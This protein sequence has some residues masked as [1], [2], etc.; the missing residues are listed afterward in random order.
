MWAL[1]VAEVCE[2]DGS[3]RFDKCFMEI[4]LFCFRM[5]G[6]VEEKDREGRR[7]RDRWFIDIARRCVFRISTSYEA[8][9]VYNVIQRVNKNSI[10]AEILFINFRMK[11][12]NK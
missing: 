7:E 5:I 1:F 4:F 12:K 9:G 8:V 6:W 2:V 3:P 11:I 10:P